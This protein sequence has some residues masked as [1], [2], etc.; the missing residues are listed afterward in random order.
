LAKTHFDSCNSN[1]PLN[2]EG[3][4]YSIPLLDKVA[5]HE[6][7]LNALVHRD[8][9]TDGMV[10][11]NF[12]EDRLVV[13]S[14]GTFYGGVN[15]DNIAK[16]EPRHRNKAL[17]KMMMEYHLVDRAGMGVLRMS[18]NSLRYGR[19]FP[20]FAERGAT[21]EAAMQAEYFRPGIFVLTTDDAGLGVTELLILNSVWESGSVPVQSLITQ[22]GKTTDR[23]WP[24]VQVALTRLPQVEFCGS[25]KG[26][27]V[28]VKPEWSKLFGVTKTLRVTSASPKHVKLYQFLALHG[29]ASNAD[30]KAHLGFNST[31][32]TSGFLKVASYAK[33]SGK[34][35]NSVWSLTDI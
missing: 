20:T 23:P 26:V 18:V 3:K 21:I 28:R 25:R 12:T 1:L 2:Y 5:F 7:Y 22:L 34:A 14:P 9:S 27:F 30:I 11:V 13:T 4:T 16:H 29:S 24:A 6:A 10:S 17:A 31:S 32:Q 19:A 35:R 8:Y 15:S 33:R